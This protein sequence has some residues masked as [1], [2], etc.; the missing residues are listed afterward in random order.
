VL[1]RA[2]L[3]QEDAGGF[4]HHFGADLAPLQC[5]RIALGG[6]ADLVA[7]DDQGGAVHFDGALE[8]A[9]HRVVLEHVGQVVRLQQI[10][11]GDDLDVAVEILHRRTQDVAAD[12]PEPVDADLDCHVHKLLQPR[13]AASGKGPGF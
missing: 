4:D 12:A 10:V 13:G 5:S 2:F 9:V 3:G 1:L 7:I 11:D 8:A 6:Q